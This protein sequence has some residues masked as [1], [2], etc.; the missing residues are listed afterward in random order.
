[1]IQARKSKSRIRRSVCDVSSVCNE[2]QSALRFCH[3]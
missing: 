3:M 1:L 2:S